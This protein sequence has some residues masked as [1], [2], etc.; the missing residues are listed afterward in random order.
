MRPHHPDTQSPALAF[1]QAGD[2]VHIVSVGPSS[3]QQMGTCLPTEPADNTAS[4]PGRTSNHSASN[5]DLAKQSTRL[6]LG[7]RAFS[8][9]RPCVWN[10][11]PTDLKALMDTRVFRCKLNLFY[12]HQHTLSTH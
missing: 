8:F 10:Q 4:V 11:L 7:E 3:Y 2:G 6:K 12:F 5:N 9:A 1:S